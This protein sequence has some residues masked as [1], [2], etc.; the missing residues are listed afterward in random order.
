[1]KNIKKI[2]SMVLVLAMVVAMTA[3][4]GSGGD[5]EGGDGGDG[6]RVAFIARASADTF[7]AWLTREMQSEAEKYDDITLEYFSGEGDNN[8]VN[9]LLEDCVTKQYDLVIVQVNDNAASA[10]YVKQVVDAG[11]PVITTSTSGRPG[12][13]R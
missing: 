6:Y 4:S 2:L 7:A 1:M 12:R 13:N 5:S 3:C 8:Q 9:S 10:P 11:I